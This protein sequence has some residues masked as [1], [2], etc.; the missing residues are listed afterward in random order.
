MVEE[1]NI[2]RSP[3]RPKNSGGRINKAIGNNVPRTPEGL[4]EKGNVPRSPGRPKGSRS[5]STLF[6]EEL[7]LKGAKE[8]YLK[9]YS[10]A[11]EGDVTACKIILD[12][13]YP[14]PKGRKHDLGYYGQI[15]TIQ[16]V[17]ELSKHVLNMVI[18]GKLS[19]EE[20]EDHSR[21]IERRIKV[22]TD[23]SVMDR[24]NTTC[25]KIDDL[26]NGM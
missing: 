6:L 4:F 7:G 25:Q 26:K 22:I 3:G 20:A 24:I 18:S 2:K 1:N 19:A 15:D 9:L 13:V 14:V 17:N 23:S 10:I 12:R 5:K 16:D 21:E 8:I 11:L